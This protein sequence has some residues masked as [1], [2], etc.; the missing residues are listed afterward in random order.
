MRIWI[1]PL[2]VNEAF[3][4]EDFDLKKNISYAFKF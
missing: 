1:K 2:S 4:G 3:K